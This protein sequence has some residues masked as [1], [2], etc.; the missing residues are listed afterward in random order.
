MPQLDEPEHLMI[1]EWKRLN[2][3]AIKQ[4][5]NTRN[6]DPF[7]SGCGV[8]TSVDI[9]ARTALL[10]YAGDLLDER[11]GVEREEQYDER[12]GCFIFFFVHQKKT[13]W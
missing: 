12:N 5:K 9:E 8:F 6:C 11:E 1:D 3:K 4:I 10:Q 7:I 13:Q 2:I